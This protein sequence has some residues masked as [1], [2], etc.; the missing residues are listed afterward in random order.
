MSG[1]QGKKNIP[2]ITVSYGISSFIGPIGQKNACLAAFDMS[3][4]FIYSIDDDG[5]QQSPNEVYVSG[6]NAFVGSCR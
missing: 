5:S 1:Y 3:W 6:L 2:R 4:E